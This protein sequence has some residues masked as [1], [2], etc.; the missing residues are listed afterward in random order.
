M[1]QPCVDMRKDDKGEYV[2]HPEVHQYDLD[3]R[4][5]EV[6]LQ[7]KCSECAHLLGSE[8]VARGD[9]PPE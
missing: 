6:L 1:G 7:I 5:D 3:G 4:P 2:H 8:V 9:V